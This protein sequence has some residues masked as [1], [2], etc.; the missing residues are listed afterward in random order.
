MADA[1]LTTLAR[2]LTQAL[3]LDRAPVQVSYLDH[4]PAQLTEHPGGVP[5][6][7]TFFAQGQSES[8]FAGTKAHEDCEIGAFVLGIPPEGELGKRVMATIGTMQREGYLAPGE[9][10]KVPH[11]ATAPRFVAYGPLGS[12]SVAPT[13]VL[14]FARPKSAMLALEAAHFEAPMNGR[15]MCAIMPVLNGGAK[16][17]VSMGCIGSRIYSEMGDDRLVVGI[18]GD[19]LDQFLADLKKIRHANEVVGSEDRSRKRASEE[20]RRSG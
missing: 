16:V 2:E 1:H 11:N 6:V 14:L 4:P 12:L 20:R 17:A 19:Y 18:R 15:P 8:F 3:E 7:C 13:N 9:E 5:S 10:A